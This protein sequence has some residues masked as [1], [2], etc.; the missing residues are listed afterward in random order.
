[1]QLIYRGINYKT[2]D[3]QTKSSNTERACQYNLAYDE[4]AQEL[5]WVRQI[6]YYTYRGVSYTKSPIVNAKA[7]IISDK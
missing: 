5:V 7:R 6:Q 3:C 2:A 1:M 4:N